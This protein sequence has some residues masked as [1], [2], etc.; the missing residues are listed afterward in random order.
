MSSA[1]LQDAVS[2][3][4]VDG[5]NINGVLKVLSP[6]PDASKKRLRARRRT[7]RSKILTSSPYKKELMEK[8][9]DPKAVAK[10]KN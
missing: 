3:P 6:L 7:Q 5:G 10:K 4:S 2:S 9:K 8:A 1:T